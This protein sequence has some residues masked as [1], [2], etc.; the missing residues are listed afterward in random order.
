MSSGACEAN[1]KGAPRQVPR[2]AAG[3]LGAVL[4]SAL[5][6]FVFACGGEA[7]P[8]TPAG[9]LAA[10]VPTAAA[11]P[12]PLATPS[13]SS[14][15][16]G[17]R[18]PSQGNAH[19]ALGQAHPP[20]NSTPATSGWHYAVPLAPVPWGLYEKPLPDEVLI[21]NLEHGGIGVH[22]DCPEGCADLVDDIVA[23]IQSQR[24]TKI[25]VSPYPAMPTRIAL[26]A[27]NYLDAFDDFDGDR[28][29]AFIEAH[30]SSPN[31]P[32]YNVP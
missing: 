15:I 31:A 10:D 4:G 6:A 16:P 21:H 3:P 20:Y 32:E 17:E 22:Y 25:L 11:T 8:A 19:I 12:T 14:T 28:I 5:M 24:R 9:R 2:G 30:E 1:D 23:A 27:W 18:Y 29:V 13:L 7:A 26:T